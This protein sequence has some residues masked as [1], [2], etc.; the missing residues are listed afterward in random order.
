VS[1]SAKDL[2]PA[3]L[4]YAG[5]EYLHLWMRGAPAPPLVSTGTP[6][7]RG[8]LGSPGSQVLIGN[9]TFTGLDEDGARFTL[10][11]WLSPDISVEANYFFVD[12][13]KAVSVSSPGT[14]VLGRPFIN[15][16][17]GLP[18][19]AGVALPGLTQGSVAAREDSR[20]WG[21][22]V[23]Y[24]QKFWC[25]DHISLLALV[26]A[27]YLNLTEGLI[28]DE[29]VSI[30]PTV[31]V[32]G[33]LSALAEDQFGTRNSIIAGQ[34]G[35]EGELNYCRFFINARVKLALGANIEDATILGRTRSPGA[36]PSP[37]LNGAFLA[38][39][40]NIGKRSR[41][42]FVVAPEGI[43][44]VGVAL[45]EWMRVSIGYDYLL[46]SDV[47]RPGNQIDQVINPAQGLPGSF[48]GTGP[49]I[50]PRPAFIVKDSEF[51]VQGITVNLEIRF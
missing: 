37:S 34:V 12:Q 16:I 46:L 24:R 25:D 49:A 48:G 30:L 21:G 10:G 44:S 26:G 1:A 27:R 51:W 4:W 40:T 7:S 13:S 33:G 23:T 15:A 19:A 8:S 32:I 31:P 5:A 50:P 47:L 9:D 14:P 28:V 11:T 45:T 18:A 17:T 35:L 43:I 41:T 29:S 36:P 2:C 3:F 39:P 6:A 42:Q 20:L 38:L 22:E